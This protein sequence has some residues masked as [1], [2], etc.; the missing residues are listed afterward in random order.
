MLYKTVLNSDLH[1]LSIECDDLIKQG[2]TPTGG[3]IRIVDSYLQVLYKPATGT[4]KVASKVRKTL[5][6]KKSKA[7]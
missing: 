2:Y 3:L 5:T 7:A 1:A 6:L 4:Q